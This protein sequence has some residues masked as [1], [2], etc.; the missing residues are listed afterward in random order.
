MARQRRQHPVPW[1]ALIVVVVLLG[2]GSRRFG[3]HLPGFLTA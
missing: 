2:L 1:L 3:P